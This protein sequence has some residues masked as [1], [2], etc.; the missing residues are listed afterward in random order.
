MYVY[1]F[2]TISVDIC[3]KFDE[4]FKKNNNKIY[5]EIVD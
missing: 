4:N 2:Y 1:Y 5:I 3:F